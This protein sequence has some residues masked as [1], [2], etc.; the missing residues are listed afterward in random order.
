MVRSVK[1]V[2]NRQQVKAAVR[3]GVIGVLLAIVGGDAVVTGQARKY[4]G[5]PVLDVLQELQA[6]GLRLLFSSNLVPPTLLVKSEPTSR[7][8]RQ[9]AQQVLAP[10]GLT[11]QNGPRGTLL[12]V[13]DPPLPADR[14]PAPRPQRRQQPVG[15]HPTDKSSPGPDP[16]TLRIEEFVDVKHRF[17]EASTG[18]TA[19]SVGPE[20]IRETAGGFE[21][22][23]QVFQFLPGA[24]AINDDSG[25]L[26]VRGAGPEHNIVVL[27]GVQ[28][29]NPYRFSELTSSFLNPDTAASVSLDA[30]G[31]DARYGGRLSSV[32]SIETRDGVRSRRLAISASLGL[33][34]GNVLLEGRLPRTESGSWWVTARGTYYRP[35][36]GA[37]RSGVMPSFGD[38]QFKVALKPS[39][40]TSLSILG[41]SGRETMQ[42][43]GIDLSSPKTFSG[44][45][46][47][48]VMNLSWT[49]SARLATTTTVSAYGHR[50]HDYDAE[51][52]QV[53][54]LFERRIEVRDFA[55]GQRAV[56]AVS[57]N[58]LL[59]LGVDV[60]RMRSSWLMRGMQP[61]V[62]WRGV[63]P[64]TWGEGVEYPP[65][66]V[67]DSALSRTQLGFWLQDRI[68][69]G[70]RVSLQPGVRV[71]WN[72]FTSET[73]WQPRVRVATR[74][75]TGSV[76]AGYAEQVQTPSHEGL[77]GYDYFELTTSDARLRNERSRQLVIGLQQELG[78]GVEL[79]VEAYRRRFDRL[80]LQRL[81]TDAERTRRL[82]LYV[83]PPDMP[84]DDVLLE[85]RPTIYPESNGRGTSSGVEV[86]VQ[87]SGTRL[88]GWIGYAFSNARREAYGYSFP[89]DF[90]RPHTLT[91]VAN[92]PLGSRFRLSTS[93]LAA[94]GF[95]ITP[96]HQEV[97]FAPTWLPDGTIDPIMRPLRA[98]DGS[99]GLAPN[100]SMRRMSLRNS[101]RLSA[102]SRAD[103]RV[104]YAS[105]GRW[106]F[107]GEVI[108]V[109]GTRNYRQMFPSP[110]FGGGAGGDSLNNVYESFDR[111]PSFGVRV[112]F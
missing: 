16:E 44:S 89:F 37:F 6:A 41:I 43:H 3:A 95:A 8:P 59:D 55:A 99:L 25:K 80:L 98:S 78:F 100:A 1:T 42:G 64:S 103:V 20:V 88:S 17:D 11:L 47:L 109:L 58:H 45:N 63:G 77:Q 67:I 73:A 50:A 48:G 33:A 94:S 101:E 21:N 87:R 91:A 105:G 26:A 57:A 51:R 92:M 56:Y 27:D 106:E 36:V 28:I 34:N 5:R 46:Q 30:S 84:D 2:G 23:F 68:P 22:P 4:Q 38:V 110:I 53:N 104:T 14:Q 107:Y 70:A 61:P 111:F 93:V 75:G 69:L 18:T 9:L 112:T 82:A 83:L 31:L 96:F 10:H 86:L 66:G 13:A 39:T 90:D 85:R 49:P 40:T 35:V 108:N 62:F 72:S 7:N 32:T 74:I 60:H 102:Y 24:A 54:S 52:Q 76:W 12:V 15:D 19:H 81:E 65:T 97:F 29:H 71:D 79:R